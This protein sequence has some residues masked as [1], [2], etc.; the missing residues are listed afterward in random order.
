MIQREGRRRGEERRGGER[1]PRSGA[2]EISSSFSYFFSFLRLLFFDLVSSLPL[3]S[4]LPSLSY[5]LKLCP[6]SS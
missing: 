6:R 1:T 2:G 5:L 4:L 3:W